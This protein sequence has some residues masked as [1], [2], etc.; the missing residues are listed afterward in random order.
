MVQGNDAIKMA[1]SVIDYIFRELAISY[2]DRHDLAHVQKEDLAPDTVGDGAEEQ[3]IAAAN[4]L[5]EQVGQAARRGYARAAVRPNLVVLPGG[6]A[7]ATSSEE[8]RAG[9]TGVRPCRSRW[10]PYP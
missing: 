7:Q 9:N 4:A 8:R 6:I 5:L 3:S 2:L 1:T 10:L